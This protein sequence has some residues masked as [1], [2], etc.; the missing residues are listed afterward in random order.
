[1]AQPCVTEPVRPQ[2]IEDV[3][4]NVQFAPL[5]PGWLNDRYMHLEDEYAS[6]KRRYL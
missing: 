4:W 3:V 5:S 1:M 6:P 2:E